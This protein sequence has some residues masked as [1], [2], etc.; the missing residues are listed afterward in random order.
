MIKSLAAISFLLL[1]CLSGCFREENTIPRKDRGSVETA[2][3]DL[4]PDYNGEIYYSFLAKK[5]V[6]TIAKHSWDISL[7]C[8]PS[9]PFIALNTSKS[10]Y[11]YSTDKSSFA[12][13]VDTVGKLGNQLNDYPCGSADSLALT[14]ILTN[15]LVYIIDLGVDENYQKAGFI[16]MKAS[17]AGQGYFIEYS[18]ISGGNHHSVSIP[19]DKTSNLVFFSFRTKAVFPEPEIPEWDILMT[20]YQHVYY[21]PFQT[22]A[23]V[24]CLINQATMQACEYKGSKAFNEIQANDT[25]GT[26]F[27]VRRNIIGFGWKY[28]DLNNNQYLIN[29]KKTYFLKR[30][31]GN[32]YKLHFIG[33]YNSSGIKGTATFEFQEI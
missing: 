2:I 6:A 25:L 9:N 23:V 29:S 32:I 13:I 26:K 21:D 7:S 10:M 19:F 4:G 8:D 18:N 33:F 20:Q 31:T 16:L 30:N 11:A 14:G 22:Y 3:A 28:F 17:L 5:N 12:E 15:K 1:L 24:G 27:S